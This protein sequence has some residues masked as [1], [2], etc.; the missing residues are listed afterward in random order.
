VEDARVKKKRC[1]MGKGCGANEQRE[2]GEDFDERVGFRLGKGE[3]FGKRAR[4]GRA[5]VLK[6][7]VSDPSLGV[8]MGS[9]PGQC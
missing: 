8:P 2:A 9:L 6:N 7:N 1:E 5:M 3:S 4:E